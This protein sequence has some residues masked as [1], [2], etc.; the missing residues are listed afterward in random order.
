MV[1][2]L[3]ATGEGG[4]VSTHVAYQNFKTSCVYV[5]SM[6]HVTVENSAKFIG[7]YYCFSQ[8]EGFVTFEAQEK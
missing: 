7:L 6:L 2:A 4:W 1:E 8:G 3:P 5:L